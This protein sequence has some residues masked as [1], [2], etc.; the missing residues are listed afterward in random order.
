[1]LILG[2]ALDPFLSSIWVN[3]LSIAVICLIL[4]LC[5]VLKP[6]TRTLLDELELKPSEEMQPVLI[7]IDKHSA[8]DMGVSYNDTKHA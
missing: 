5:Q 8:I 1:M 4:L 6:N 2:E 3:L 7:L